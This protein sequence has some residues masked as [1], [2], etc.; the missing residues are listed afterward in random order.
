MT[1]KLAYNDAAGKTRRAGDFK[2]QLRLVAKA[3]ALVP[4]Q[5]DLRFNPGGIAVYGEVTLHTDSL[6]IQASH[7]CDL[8][9][10]VRSCKG[11]KD[12][13]GGRNMWFPVSLLMNSPS[14][15]ALRSVS[16]TRV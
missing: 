7:G 16:A 9:V 2:R 10:L 6:Y 8:G 13:S 11:R 14:E 1:I 3:L 15:F 5:Y 4:G 12:Y